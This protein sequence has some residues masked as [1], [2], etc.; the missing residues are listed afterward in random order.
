MAAAQK[1]RKSRI[2][3]GECFVKFVPVLPAVALGAVR[4]AVCE[5]FC[6]E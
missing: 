4:K 1:A 3:G 5:G 2:F 6:L